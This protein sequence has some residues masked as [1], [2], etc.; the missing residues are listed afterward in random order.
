MKAT[1]KLSLVL[2]PI[3]AVLTYVSCRKNDQSVSPEPEKANFVEERF[4]NSNRT[5]DS[6]EKALVDFVKRKN[7][8][9]KFVDKTVKQIG[10]PQ[11]NKAVKFNRVSP[12][13]GRGFSDSGSITYVPFVRD[14]QNFVNASLIIATS[15]SDT[16]F[17]YL[18]DWQYSLFGFTPSPDS[19]WNAKDVFHLF[20]LLDRAVFNRNSFVITDNRLF[21][22]P[23]PGDSVIVT[24]RPSQQTGNKN[25]LFIY[26]TSCDYIDIC[27]ATPEEYQQGCGGVCTT[28]CQYYT[29]TEEECSTYGIY[30][31]DTGGG[32]SGGGTGGSTSGTGG[33]GGSTPPN[34]PCGGPVASRGQINEGCTPGW[35]PPIGGGTIS[36]SLPPYLYSNLTKP[37]LKNA[38]NKLSGGTAN[39]FFKQIYNIFDTS[40]VNHLFIDEADLTADTAYGLAYSPVMLPSGGVSFT[41]KMDTVKLM[42]CSQ[43]WMAYV[44]IHEVAHAAMFAN[45][46]QWDTANTQHENM[47]SQYLTQM[48]SSLTSAYAGLSMYDAYAICYTGFNNGIDGNGASAALLYLMLKKVKQKLNNQAINAQQLITRGEEF[49]DIGTAGIRTGCN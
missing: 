48:A 46:I 33:G 23:N 37:C 8:K 24:L 40:T 2:L 27:F 7:I 34:N 11:W 35:Y 14:T 42:T 15:T 6:T 12:K 19:T 49:T 32:T 20:A 25:S 38:L 44:L 36:T 9:E 4:F 13:A 10:Y 22:T 18:C 28:G 45:V 31:G 3:I 29:H 47:M 26:V 5:A 1:I 43:Q 39:T 21:G 41:I 30:I 16:V 17:T